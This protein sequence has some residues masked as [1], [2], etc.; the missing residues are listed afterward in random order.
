MF[1]NDH[2][3]MEKDLKL[4]VYPGENG[5]KIPREDNNVAYFVKKLY[6]QSPYPHRLSKF[7]INVLKS[8]F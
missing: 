4:F 8:Y 1:I 3:N 7:A 6:R 2:L 5:F